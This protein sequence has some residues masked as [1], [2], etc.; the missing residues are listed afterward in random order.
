VGYNQY[1]IDVTSTR[2]LLLEDN[3]VTFAANVQPSLSYYE[4]QNLFARKNLST[5]G[6]VLA[7]GER[8]RSMTA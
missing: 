7:P 1:G 5:T 3:L 4:V 6:A 2:D 8:P